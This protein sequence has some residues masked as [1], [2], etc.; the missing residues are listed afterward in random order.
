MQRKRD[1]GNDTG[2]RDR[3]P[4][5]EW[6]GRGGREGV[7]VDLRNRGGEKEEKR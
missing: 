5:I 4:K 1:R 2:G 6:R 3:V 7:Q